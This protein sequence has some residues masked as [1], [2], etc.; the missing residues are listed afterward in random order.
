MSWE[1]AIPTWTFGFDQEFQKYRGY[2]PRPYLPILA[3][4]TIQSLEVSQRF[5]RDYSRTLSDCFMNNCYAK[6]GELCHR[7]GLQWHSESGGPW[8][9]D[10]LLF[11]QADALAFWGRNDMPQGEFW[12]PGTPTIGRSNGKQAAMAAH[13]YGR[14]LVS[15]ESFTHMVPHW[16]AYPA[17]LKPGA[18]AAFCDGSNR[19]VWHTF[20]ASPP[21][22]GKPG[23]VYFAGTHLNPNVTWWEQA[24]AFLTYLGRCQ[25]LLQQGRFQSDVCCYRSDKNYADWNR[26]PKAINPSF[27]LPK[28][29]A[30]D[31]VNTEALL[32]RL[33]VKDGSLVL[34]DGMR[35]RLMVVDPEEESLPPEALRKIIQ[36]VRE[37]A[38]VVLGPRRPHRAPGLTNFP[39][40]DQEVCRL[41]ADLWAPPDFLSFHRQLGKG[42]VIGGTGVDQV[43]RRGHPPRLRWSVGLHP[44]PLRGL[45]RLL[46]GRD[47]PGRMHIP[48]LWQGAGALGSHLWNDPRC[49]LFP[50]H[51]GWQDRC[52]PHPAGERLHLRRLS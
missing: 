30:Y 36:L 31:L 1:G 37:G 32:E 12:W 26:G 10:T 17:A 13:L 51:G 3:G 43:L 29:Y 20:S 39:T 35:Y 2:S 38:T 5:L 27:G 45:G 25:L 40:C 22:F 8:R 28:G 50:H 49:R 4:L 24:S 7:A 21:E 6:L 16:S 52:A 46:P 9:R 14:P 34:P 47:R 41:A 48:R 44:P 23:I 11:A 19:L 18:D 33:S 42:K 15:M